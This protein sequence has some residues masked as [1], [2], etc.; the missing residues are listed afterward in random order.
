MDELENLAINLRRHPSLLLIGR[1]IQRVE[2]GEQCY[3]AIVSLAAMLGHL[4][5]LGCGL[6]FSLGYGCAGANS[7]IA[8]KLLGLSEVDYKKH[9]L[10]TPRHIFIPSSRFSDA[11]LEPNKCVGYDGKS[12]VLPHIR[13]AY[14]AS[15]AMFTRHQDT[16][17]LL[18]AWQKLDTIITAEPF[19]TATARLSDIVLPVALESERVDIL[20]SSGGHIF[21]L[22][23]EIKPFGESRS[24]YEIC[25]GICEIWGRG[26]AFSEGKSEL[27]WV[28][29]IYLDARNKAM[30]LGYE[31]LPSFDE[32]WQRGYFK[33]DKI[34]EKKHY[35]TRFFDFVNG[36]RSLATNS[37][38][39]E[40]YSSELADMG[41]ADFSGYASW[42]EPAEWARRD[43]FSLFLISPHSKHRLHSQLDNSLVCRNAKINGLEPVVMSEFDAGAR[44]LK[45]GDI[46]RV[47]NDRGEILCGVSV[48]ARVG[49]G[50]VLVC[51]GAW[52]EPAIWG[53]PSLCLGGNANVL[54]SDIGCSSLS[55][56][57]CAHTALV[58]VELFSGKIPPKSPLKL[59]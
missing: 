28:R 7:Y 52:Y 37:G 5:Q 54:T 32:F 14:N 24:D 26:L 17:R 9:G 35:Y 50:V 48:S 55:H 45:D 20:A 21:A 42:H 34:D 38:K 4:G 18:K 19:W 23:G 33:F 2:N 13:V 30:N 57:N 46:V 22:K 36:G 29:E 58:E 12:L 51:E 47:Y 39:I 49:R 25:R 56:S 15:G 8:P 41:Y 6:D 27:E 3:H 44:G 59:C 53:E 40:I 1:S 43:K 10:K 31:N 11:L 16:N